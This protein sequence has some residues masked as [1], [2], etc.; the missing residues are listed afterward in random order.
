MIF[1]SEN[2]DVQAWLMLKILRKKPLAVLLVSYPACLPTRTLNLEP[3]C[4]LTWGEKKNNLSC[5]SFQQKDPFPLS[6]TTQIQ[7]IG[8]RT[9]WI[10]TCGGCY[11]PITAPYLRTETPVLPA[12][13]TP[14]S[15][16]LSTESLWL[17]VTS[18]PRGSSHSMIG[19]W[20][21]LQRPGF[22]A[23]T[24]DNSEWPSRLP[25]S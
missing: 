5:A 15:L 19:G 10:H 24:Q 3:R 22:L 16:M 17:K 6:P 13:D 12:A 14:G 9:S 11:D 25:G 20:W 1:C 8:I 7:P 2:E 23:P 18:P 4:S 21:K